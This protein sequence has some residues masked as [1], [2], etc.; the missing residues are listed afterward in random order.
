MNIR[1]KIKYIVTTA[2]LLSVTIACHDKEQ[3]K[4]TTHKNKTK[5]IVVSE[6]EDHGNSIDYDL[7]KVLET[8]YVIDR[9]GTDIKDQADSNSKT[10][11]TYEYGEKLS[12]IEINEDWLGIMD[13][14]TR[15]YTQKDGSQVTSNGWEKV[16]VS[17]KALGP[18]SQVYLIESD[19]N[20][21]LWATINNKTEHFEKGKRLNDYLKIELI[22]QK[23]F[24]SKKN[25][26]VSFLIAD[27]S[28]VKKVNGVIE[29]KCSNKIKKLIDK[30]D[31]EENREEYKYVGQ[32]DFL[33]K[34]VVTG[35]YWESS[36][37][38]FFDKITGE[39]SQ[40]FGDYPV[41]S[42]DKKNIIC[43]NANPYEET[44]DLELYSI[45]N[46]NKIDAVLSVSF[47]NWM[48][49]SDMFWS[50][51]NYLYMTVNRS[52]SFWKEDGNINDKYQY[53]RI[54]VLL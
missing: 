9:K 38:K 31:A 48:P 36:D 45:N 4:E 12:V 8:I 20:L 46:M 51:D 44:G 52:S 6:D 7:T 17:R 54:K 11:G 23:V 25:T 30:P 33:N 14:I 5:E 26:S 3:K 49:G 24:D 35:S 53:L 29:L 21:I 22:D 10:L 43:I 2:I 27:S 39:E 32:I 37:Y 13:R 34:Y 28:E 50:T 42:P 47:K 16:Y 18:I 41:I 1:M 40:S 19:L 15:K